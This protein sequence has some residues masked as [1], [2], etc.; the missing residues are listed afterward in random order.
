MGISLSGG[1]FT[2]NRFNLTEGSKPDFLDMDKDGDKE[3][4][5]KKAIKDKK[6]KKDCGCKKEEDCDCSDKKKD[7]KENREMAYGGG[8]PGKGSGDGSKP[9][10]ITNGKAYTMKGKDGKPLFAKEDMTITKEMVIEYLVSEGYASNEVS[11]EILHTHVSDRFLESIEE[12]ITEIFQGKHGQSEKQYQDSRSP[13]GKMIS[14]DSKG[15]GAN[16]SYKAK[17]TGPNPAGGSQKPQGQAKMNNKDRAFLS[18]LKANK[19]ANK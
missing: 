13:A 6:G 18:H 7:V 4:S 1:P 10:G 9:K 12:D 16:Y 15:S 19:K 11:A 2:Y 14:G 8:K 5:F 3:E 17:N